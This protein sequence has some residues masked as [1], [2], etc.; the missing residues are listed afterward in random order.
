MKEI[1]K[2]DKSS[3][4]PYYYQL[5]QLLRGKIESG[6]LKPGEALP[7]ESE[8]CSMFEVSRTVVR[9][10]LDKLCQDGIIY[11]KRGKGT[12]VAKPKIQE[13]FIQRTYGF[14]QDMKE[15][16]FEVK[17]KVLEQRLIEPPVRIKSLLKLAEG[18]KVVKISRLRYL[19]GELIMLT[20][21]YIRS[22]FCPGLEKE[23]LTEGSLYQRLWDKYGLKISYGYRTLEAVA[24]GKY[25]ADML[26]VPKGSPLVYLESISYVKNGKPIECFEAWHRGDRC[27]FAV[28]VI[29]TDEIKMRTPLYKPDSLVL[30]GVTTTEKKKNSG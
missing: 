22:E 27:K 2:I 23:D 18:E 16:G 30:Y 14:Y 8:L 13:K 21:S 10:A 3:P 1:E 28:E 4:I 5:E 29:L 9:Q 15:K 20:T 19:S 24:A 26:K 17:S 6:E 25:E 11:K 12:F 7:S